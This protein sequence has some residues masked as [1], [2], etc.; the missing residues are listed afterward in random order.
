M[1][2]II[3]PETLSRIDGWKV[4]ADLGKI[5]ETTLKF[6]GKAPIIDKTDI[7]KD[8]ALA[9]TVPKE[10]WSEEMKQNYDG[11]VKWEEM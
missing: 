9:V 7:F 8:S 5:E 4:F 3:L 6:Y 10:S 2:E 1:K 11:N